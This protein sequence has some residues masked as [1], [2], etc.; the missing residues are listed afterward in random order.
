MEALS[1]SCEA[2]E[3][4]RAREGKVDAHYFKKDVARGEGFTLALFPGS[5]TTLCH[6]GAHGRH[7]EPGEGVSPHGS[8]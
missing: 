5:N 2:N 1:V 3:K 8:V 6:C 4:R 7:C